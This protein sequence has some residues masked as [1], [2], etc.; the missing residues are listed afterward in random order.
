[1]LNQGVERE[2][3]A[4]SAFHALNGGVV[5]VE[6][7]ASTIKKP[8]FESEEECRKWREVHKLPE[9]AKIDVHPGETLNV[10]IGVD[11][12]S[13]TSK[14]VLMTEDEKV[15]DRFYANN[16]GDP[17][18]VV[19]RGFAHKGKTGTEI[20]VI[21]FFFSKSENK[22]MK[23][24]FYSP[25]IYA[26]ILLGI[27]VSCTKNEAAVEEI[28]EAE[29][30]QI[31]ET[32]ETGMILSKKA[33]L[34]L[35]GRDQKM[36]PFVNLYEG[37]VVSLLE[38]DG[39]IDT[40]FV[41]DEVQADGASS[42]AKT[43]TINQNPQNE[44]S[45]KNGE[46]DENVVSTGSTT[47]KQLKV[48]EYAHAVYDNVDFWIEKSV[49]ALNSEK[50]VVIE[51]ATLYA[52]YDLTQ[53]L[54]A[55]PNPL[56]FAAIVGKS[57]DENPESKSVKIFFYDTN[58]KS[59]REAFVS[60]SSISTRIDDIEVSKIAEQLKN[61][62]RAALRN[63]LFR[64]AAKYRPCQK[65]LAALNANTET[66]KTYDYQEVLKSVKKIGIGVNVDELL[67]VDQSKD[68]FK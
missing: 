38:L 49:F 28:P 18:N 20:E 44:E 67:T 35:F 61:T 45:S 46:S 42:I 53:K 36:H 60:K 3:I 39:V 22:N 7:Q 11:A 64:K 56:K 57:F 48:T 24:K 12:G 62:K 37:D 34:C 2:D 58:A 47:D 68:P 1:M 27:T 23:V 10:Y 51:P 29:E 54:D 26:L 63:E 66:K 30:P 32:I 13:T 14:L 25:I 41:P 6:H 50:A 65:V 16:R 55:S 5:R 59:V 43:D 15:F 19:R 9:L 52:V 33:Q 40:K 8:Y 21:I 31:T 4:L 17:I